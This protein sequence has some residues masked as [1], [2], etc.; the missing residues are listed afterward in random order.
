MRNLRFAALAAIVCACVVPSIYAW[1]AGNWSTLPIVGG[2]SFSGGTST[3][4]SG[5]VSTSTVPAGPTFLTGSEEI[6]ADTNLAGG[7]SPQTVTIPVAMLGN[8]W[9]TPRNYLDNGALAI[10]NTNTTS[11]VTC[12][13]NA[14]IA[15]TGMSA[16]RWGCQANVTS[17]AGRTAIV[18]SSPSPPTGFQNVMKVF[19][20]SG[21][22]LQPIC[23]WQ[24]IPTPQS[25][26]LQGQV[27]TFSFYAAALAGLAADNNNQM[28]A[29]VI[30]GT[31]TDEKLTATPT[32]SPAI[33]PAWTGVATALNSTLT[34]TTTF[35]RYAVQATIP[36]AATEVGV[37]LC[38]TPTATGAGATDGFAWTGAQLERSPGASP[39][40][41]RS[42]VDDLARA[43]AFFYNL[44]EGAGPT[45]R[46]LCTF[47]TANTVAQCAINYPV[48]MYSAPTLTF[49][50]G[51]AVPT[52]TAQTAL[53]ACTGF[54]ADATEGA[55]VQSV[56]MTLAQCTSGGT[57]AAVGLVLPL[58]DNGGTGSFKA[59]NGF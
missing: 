1:A 56:N 31:G 21:A 58:F 23:V 36:A 38:F 2:A 41:F 20:T 42:K 28:Q 26:Q 44:T 51:F 6:P 14:A 9:G 29:V 18:T 17:G 3:G 55:L 5:T 53:T 59:W 47:S 34:I 7:A 49:A 11:T 4:S 15:V 45:P 54:A 12:A 22:L 30:S 33:T 35:T 10:T 13:V 19:R 46:A 57:T 52:T 27:V 37:G 8:F 48:T 25:T 43:Q 24:A 16:D 50:N 40:E 32:T 39:F